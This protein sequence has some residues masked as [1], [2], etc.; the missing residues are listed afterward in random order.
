M[1]EAENGSFAAAANAPRARSKAM[2]NCFSGSCKPMSNRFGCRA[3]AM[4]KRLGTDGKTAAED[5][6]CFFQETAGCLRT[7]SN[8]V[9]KYLCA[10]GKTARERWEAGRRA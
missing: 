9:C 8:A 7:N 6:R 10:G 5:E 3:D 4:R 2:G 1:C